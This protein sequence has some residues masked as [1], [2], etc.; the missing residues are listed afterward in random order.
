MNLCDEILNN[1]NKN[2][3]EKFTEDKF[4]QID[5]K[6]LENLLT[7]FAKTKVSLNT[8]FLGKADAVEVESDDLSKSIGV[9]NN[10]IDT[11]KISNMALGPVEGEYIENLNQYKLPLR[12][13]WNFKD[14]K[15]DNRLLFVAYWMFNKNKWI[16]R[17]K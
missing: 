5:F 14:G 7:K 17:S 15:E 3:K 9:L 4:N 16:T 13:V 12:I 1:V 8:K 11:I 6:A 10:V 2:I